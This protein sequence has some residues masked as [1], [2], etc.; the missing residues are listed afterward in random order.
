MAGRYLTDMANVLRAAGL[1]VVEEAGWETRARSTGGYLDGRPK[2]IMWHHTASNATPASDILYM[3]RNSGDRPI[4]NI[5]LARDGK[6]HVLAAGATN[7]NGKGG[8]LSFSKGTVPIDTM[9]THSIAIEA[10]NDGIGEPWPQVQIDAY[11]KINNALTAAYG[12]QVTDLA[13]HNLWAPTRKVDPAKAAVVQGP[14]KPGVANSYGTWSTASIQAEAV[15]RATP[16]PPPQP[17]TFP[18]TPPREPGYPV[19]APTKDDESMVVALDKNGTAWVGDGMT[20]MKIEDEATFNEYIKLAKSN[21]YRFVNTSGQGVNGWS[22]VS[23]VSDV[24]LTAL[25]RPV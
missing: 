20:R 10:A 2:A 4:A 18:P 5:Y 1:N 19:P 25:G 3:I 16:I 9:N 15:R 21:G 11:F 24:T 22:N 23:T 13:T 7:T 6:V 14:W 12:M 8:P 17:P